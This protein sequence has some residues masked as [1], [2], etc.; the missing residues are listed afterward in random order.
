MKPNKSRLTMAKKPFRRKFR[1]NR[2]SLEESIKTIVEVSS[3]EELINHIRKLQEQ[4]GVEID[5]KD[6]SIEYYGFDTRLGWET[7]IVTDKDRAVLG[8]TDG[9][10]WG[11]EYWRERAIQ[12]KMDNQRRRWM[13][14]NSAAV[15]IPAPEPQPGKF[16]VQ[17]PTGS[18]LTIT[19][20]F[21]ICPTTSTEQKDGFIFYKP[22]QE[23][24]ITAA[25]G[26]RF[27]L[28]SRAFVF[29][30]AGEMIYDPRE[31]AQLSASAHEWLAQHPEWTPRRAS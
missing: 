31:N 19:G 26:E 7:H 4:L 29:G 15:D 21:G 9:P 28:D 25:N 12:R 30:P 3:R 14:A 10:L 18:I 1:E 22:T 8:F 24:V 6:V 5:G 2:A 17:H 23:P 27:T 13:Y 16:T 11:K 20:W